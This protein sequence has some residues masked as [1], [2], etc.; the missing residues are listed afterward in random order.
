MAKL[1]M[2]SHIRAFT[3]IATCAFLP[4]CVW[5]WRY[6]RI[7]APSRDAVYFKTICR[8]A[9]GPPS[10]IYYPF[11]GIFISV[12]LEFIQLG[13]HLPSGTTTQLNGNTIHIVGWTTAGPYD[14][15]VKIRAFR[16]GSAGSIDASEFTGLS[17]PYTSADDLGPFNGLSVGN[18][19]VW[20]LFLGVRDQNPERIESLPDDLRRG[21]IEL[22]SMT[23]NGT[24]YEP[25]TLSF[26]RR[27]HVGANAIN[28]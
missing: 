5:A 26:G 6:E 16:Q 8:G 1:Q 19:Y 23:I 3:A 12:D 7:E 24:R 14:R 17:D 11:N 21:S 28:C 9:F 18:R 13:L 20:H 22:P 15:T 27:S 2:R 10:T 25:Q 4:G